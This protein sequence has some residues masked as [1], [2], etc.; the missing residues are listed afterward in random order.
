MLRHC[1]VSTSNL[2]A[3]ELLAATGLEDKSAVRAS[4]EQ[5]EMQTSRAACQPLLTSVCRAG[6]GSAQQLTF[7]IINIAGV[8]STFPDAPS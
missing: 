3:T 5:V 1:E 8:M 2:T 4:D 7:I 6:Q